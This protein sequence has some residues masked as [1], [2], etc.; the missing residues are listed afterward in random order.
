MSAA[1]LLAALALGIAHAPAQPV[2]CA[3]TIPVIAM[4]RPPIMAGNMRTTDG[5][6]LVWASAEQFLG[7]DALYEPQDA[8]KT[9]VHETLHL[10]GWQHSPNP[11]DVMFS[12]YRREPLPPICRTI[13]RPRQA[14]K[15]GR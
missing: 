9:A 10:A 13:R 11:A 15:H 2:G 1:A 4:S 12:P 3:Y 8:C 5:G 14:D 6:C 7:G